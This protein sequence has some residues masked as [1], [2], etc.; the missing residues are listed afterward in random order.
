LSGPIARARMGR[1]GQEHILRNEARC[2]FSM[3]AQK[4]ETTPTARISQE[5]LAQTAGRGALGIRQ[6]DGFAIP[7]TVGFFVAFSK[8]TANT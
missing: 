5:R 8:Q 1:L 6:P 2:V 3:G 4:K 7:R